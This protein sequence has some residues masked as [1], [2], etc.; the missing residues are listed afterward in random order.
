[1][2]WPVDPVSA[3]AAATREG[4]SM[5]ISTAWVRGASKETVAAEWMTTS[6]WRNA[7]APSF[8]E[9]EAI[10]PDVA[11]HGLDP[12]AD[13]G[14]EF[15]PELVAQPVEAIVLDHLAGEA[16]GGVG[17]AARAD[18]DGDLG[19]WDAAQDALD[20]GGAQ[21]AGGAGDEETAAAQIPLNRHQKCLPFWA[22]VVYHLVSAQLLGFPAPDSDCPDEGPHPRRGP[23][24]L[25][26][27]RL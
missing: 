16:S 4:P 27:P 10:A 2:R 17:P 5:L 14:G 18:E 24:V 21:E 11:G 3:M 15:V 22:D 6:A 7:S 13:L 19:L 20:Q 23:L 9:T 25:R 26:R 1:M 8:V 12:P